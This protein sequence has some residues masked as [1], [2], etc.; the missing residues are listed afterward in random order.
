MENEIILTNTA[1]QKTFKSYLFFWAGQLFSL[2]GSSITQFVIVWCSQSFPLLR[3]IGHY[4]HD[5]NMAIYE[6]TI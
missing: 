3:N 5:Y 6:C 4:Y 2:L 1:T